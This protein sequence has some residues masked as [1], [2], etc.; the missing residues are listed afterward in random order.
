MESHPE[1]RSD[2]GIVRADGRVTP[3]TAAD[4][5]AAVVD[6][7]ALDGIPVA[8]RHKGMLAKQAKELLSDGYSWKLLVMAS[9]Y[10]LRRSQPQNMHFIAN[11]LNM[12][13]ARKYMTRRDW[14]VALQDE[15]EIGGS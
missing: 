9:V 7:F 8:S 10:S 12:A 13:G 14:D 5:I 1:R 15:M 2:E 6:T 3:A 4:V 11:D